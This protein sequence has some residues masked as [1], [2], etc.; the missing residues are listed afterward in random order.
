MM[1]SKW[2]FTKLMNMKLIFLLKLG[3]LFVGAYWFNSSIEVVWWEI[4]KCLGYH[5]IQH[6]LAIRTQWYV[7][8]SR[9]RLKMFKRTI[10]LSQH[11]L[12]LYWNLKIIANQSLMPWVLASYFLVAQLKPSSKMFVTNAWKSKICRL[13]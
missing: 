3:Y 13:R 2:G 10:K 4:K 1:L 8:G 11:H 12:R 9:F 5:F 6:L 7:P